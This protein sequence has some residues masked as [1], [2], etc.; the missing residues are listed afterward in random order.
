MPK[1]KIT[2]VK[3]ACRCG[4]CQAGDVFV[5]EDVCPP[6][7]HELWNSIYPS[8]YALLNGGTLDYGAARAKCFDAECPDGGRVKVHGEVVEND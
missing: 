4:L 6:L 7:C 8:V 3:S 1:V 5:V 2:V